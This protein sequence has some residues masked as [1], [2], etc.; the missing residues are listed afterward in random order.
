MTK[1]AE[2]F[3]VFMAQYAK[4]RCDLTVRI[5]KLHSYHIFMKFLPNSHEKLKM[6]RNNRKKMHHS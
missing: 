2:I 4:K 1:A 3:G 6:I 5:F